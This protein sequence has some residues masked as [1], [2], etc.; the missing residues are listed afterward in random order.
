MYHKHE[1]NFKKI[2][3]L[4]NICSLVYQF[5][6][7][8][9][10]YLLSMSSFYRLCPLHLNVFYFASKAL[11]DLPNFKFYEIKMPWR[12]QMP[13]HETQNTFYWIT[14]EVNIIMW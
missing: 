4:K 10:S 12:H 13:K 9:I 5:T 6:F 2:K 1:T 11:F 3:F 8:K 14:W 7:I